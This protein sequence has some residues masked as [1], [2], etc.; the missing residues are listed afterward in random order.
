MTQI[1]TSYVIVMILCVGIR[2]IAWSLPAVTQ[3]LLVLSFAR[4]ALLFVVIRRLLSPHAR[5]LPLV[6]LLGFELALGFTGFF[7]DFREPLAI[8]AFALMGASGRR[9]TARWVALFLVIAL[10]IGAA[11]T[12]TA[13]KPMIREKYSANSTNT[14]RFI[15]AIR[16][17]PAALANSQ[18]G[19]GQQ[20]DKFVGR[21]W[22]IYYPAL[23]MERVPKVLPHENGA[24]LVETAR[25]FLKPRFLFPDKGVLPSESDKVRKYS[26]VWVAGRERNTSF[27]FGYVAE[28]YVD[29]A[30]PLMLL[31]IFIFGLAMGYADRGLHKLIQNDELLAGVRA[32]I[33]W[34]TMYLYERSWV[35]MIGQALT[36]IVVLGGAAV[37]A[38]SLFFSRSATKRVTVGLD[39]P[40]RAIV[41]R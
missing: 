16:L 26:G 19:L 6:L 14:D 15:T 4:Y 39:G 29:F 33:L 5:W 36:M 22:A 27:A 34:S 20:V 3:V 13:I 1:V 8:V 41:P 25:N 10:A 21:M 30:I 32:V 9:S 40:R 24:I 18:D 7:A 23:A 37:A 31:P 2:G 38:D 12:W 28:S 11:L 17:I 35:M